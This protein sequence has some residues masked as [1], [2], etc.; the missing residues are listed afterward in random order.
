MVRSPIKLIFTLVLGFQTG[1]SALTKPESKQE[2]TEDAW[3]G[4]VQKRSVCQIPATV[5]APAIGKVTLL[6]QWHLDTS[7]NSY[8]ARDQKQNYPQAK[9]QQAIFEAIDR[10]IANKKDFILF[11]EGCEG[12]ITSTF[13]DRFNGWDYPRLQEKKSGSEFSNILTSVPL[14]LKVKWESALNVQCAESKEKLKANQLAFSDFRG[15]LGFLTRISE[16]AG[17]EAKSKPYL[18]GVN[19]IFKLPRV[20]NTATSIQ[21]LK[22]ELEKSIRQIESTFEQRNQEILKHLTDPRFGMKERIFVIGGSHSASLKKGL[23]TAGIPCEVIEPVGYPAEEDASIQR[24]RE[25]VQGL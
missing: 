4:I 8:L 21:V 11:A 16:F 25:A 6:K 18:Q 13:P 1:C 14:K 19:D 15:Q 7:A 23:E 10:Q 22:S 17:D 9:N 24:L 3:S 12:E 20:P 5:K 2:L